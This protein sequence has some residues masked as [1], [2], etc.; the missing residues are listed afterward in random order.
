VDPHIILMKTFFTSLFFIILTMPA[1]CQQVDKTTDTFKL[2]KQKELPGKQPKKMSE[3]GLAPPEKTN[4][5][6]IYT[7]KLSEP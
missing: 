2:A 3:D 1:F 7:G 4:P 6:L 5:F